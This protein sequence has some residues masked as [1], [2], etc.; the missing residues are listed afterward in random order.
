[1]SAPLSLACAPSALAPPS[2][3]SAPDANAA[4]QASAPEAFAQALDRAAAKVDAQRPA[5]ASAA[6]PAKSRAGAIQDPP[7]PLAKTG[8][9]E[10]PLPPQA[11]DLGAETPPATAVAGAAADPA[12][13]GLGV[14]ALLAQLQAAM[15]AVQPATRSAA[16]PGRADA[17]ARSSRS[18][19]QRHASAAGAGTPGTLGFDPNP[20]GGLLA[21]A[22]ASGP[23]RAE[24][25][26]IAV[27]DQNAL[28]PLPAARP[29]ELAA[30][31][32]DNLLA[33]LPAAG[34]G[35][36]PGAA[37]PG[38]SAEAHLPAAPGSPAF[39]AQLGAQ[40]TTFVRAGVE[41]ARLHLNPA[42]MGPVSVQILLDGPLAVVQ[43]SADNAHT[44][45]A[46][47]QAMP[48]LAASLREAGLTL[49]GGGVFEQRQPG[50][51]G[52]AD[53][54]PAPMRAGGA[55]DTA[56]EEQAQAIERAALRS[57]RRGVVDLVA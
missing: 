37:S 40:L 21:A 12:S 32:S 33:A 36:G 26:R 29:A 38:A 39:G 19:A 17:A 46:L 4:A 25:S 24:D 18:A 30:P 41:H 52:A 44:R 34:P 8:P 57:Q 45:Q 53:P 16:E 50:G 3:A 55:E 9:R 56:L 15:L 13:A 11:E 7:P 28:A 22:A 48:L 2:A 54:G 14:G 5:R 27:L 31:R 20:V 47:E 1:M 43:L 35:P 6:P 51:G 23:L 42:E 49:T 10:P